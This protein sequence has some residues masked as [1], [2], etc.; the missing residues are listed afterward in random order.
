M[1]ESLILYNILQVLDADTFNVAIQKINSNDL[2]IPEQVTINV[3][4]TPT[5]KF[6]PSTQHNEDWY[7]RV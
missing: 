5:V 7:T 3:L 4:R 6:Y 1:C 2:K